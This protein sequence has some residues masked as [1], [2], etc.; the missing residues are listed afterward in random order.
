MSGEI[1]I[2]DGVRKRPSWN[3]GRNSSESFPGVENAQLEML[4]SIRNVCESILGSQMLQCDVALAIKR[5][6][7]EARKTRLILARIDRRLAKVEKLR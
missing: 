1:T 6:E 4:E 5:T 2:R 3:H 7:M